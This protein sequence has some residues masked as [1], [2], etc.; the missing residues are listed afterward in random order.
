[1]VMTLNTMTQFK[2]LRLFLLP[3]CIWA[4]TACQT[5]GPF[6]LTPIGPTATSVSCSQIVDARLTQAPFRNA[7]PAKVRQWM[8]DRWGIA[9]DQ[10]EEDHQP[11]GLDVLRWK[12]AEG[13]FTTFV[14]QGRSGVS[15]RW[16]ENHRLTLN[17]ILTCFGKP[18][19]YRALDEPT[20]D[21]G[22]EYTLEMWYPEHGIIFTYSEFNNI[23][24]TPDTR[25]QLVS[26]VPPGSKES[27]VRD[28]YY[29]VNTVEGAFER[30]I[31]SLKQPWPDRIE[32]IH[33]EA[34]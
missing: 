16:E 14:Y 29:N 30:I 7:S 4:V 10:V 33:F 9:D 20:P 34:L 13:N 17:H 32:D 11:D 26:V 27:M 23:T 1:M 22:P 15:L 8:R 3:T 5:L 2:L 21:S 28:R 31:R 18:N 12:T 19:F 24:I 6:A 25:M